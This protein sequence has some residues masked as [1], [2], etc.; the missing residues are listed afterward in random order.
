MD[1]MT[2]ATM[3]PNKAKTAKPAL[4]IP[5]FEMPKFE[6]PKFE[7]PK[8][9]MPA[10]EVPAAFRD[11]AEQGIAR[12]KDGYEKIKAAAEEATDTLEDTYATA[13]KGASEYGL[14][15]I[16]ATRANTNATFD[17]A[18]KLFGVKSLSEMVEVSTAHARKQFEA[19]S[20]QNKELVAL[21]Q[22][23]ATNAAEPIKDSV[24]K[25]FHKAA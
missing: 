9:E 22:K 25:A 12:A 17:F 18:T 13:S 6:M 24:S 8:F 10:M 3:T 1:A 21:A 19:I 7:M 11:L 15:V 4:G 20:E 2:E 23:V 14:K 16:E 5:K